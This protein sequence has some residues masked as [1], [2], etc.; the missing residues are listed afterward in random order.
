MSKW[1]N[2]SKKKQLT[3]KF[4]LHSVKNVWLPFD[5]EMS[6]RWHFLAFLHRDRLNSIYAA[7]FINAVKFV[8]HKKPIAYN[9]NKIWP[10]VWSYSLSHWTVLTLKCYNYKLLGP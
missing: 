9:I 6:K 10:Q 1:Y 4:I 5:K 7:C 3:K 2:A 8:W